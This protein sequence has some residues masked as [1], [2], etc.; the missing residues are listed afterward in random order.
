[1]F[2]Q[3]LTMKNK[4][5]ALT[6]LI[7]CGGITW[8]QDVKVRTVSQIKPWCDAY[9][10]LASTSHVPTNQAV[11]AGLCGGYIVGLMEQ[12]SLSPVLDIADGT[13]VPNGKFLIGA[14][15]E[16]VTVDQVTRVFIKLVNDQ[17]QWLDKPAYL[18]IEKAGTDNRLLSYKQWSPPHSYVLVPADGKHPLK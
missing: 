18:A 16:A 9:L 8:G 11:D 10:A 3:Q 2:M 6:A 14:W 15:G 12:V 4:L 17:P 13:S 7:L 5:L 1:M